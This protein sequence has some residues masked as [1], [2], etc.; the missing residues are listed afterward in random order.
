M[1]REDRDT[2]TRAV[3]TRGWG[4]VT[5]KGRAGRWLDQPI[6]PQTL[7][8]GAPPFLLLRESKGS[9]AKV[10]GPS[11][12]NKWGLLFTWGKPGTPQ[13]SLK[14]KNHRGGWSRGADASPRGIS[15]SIVTPP[16]T[17]SQTQADSP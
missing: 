3:G 6:L 11:R 8:R 9:W 7:G 10:G 14:I 1:L 17:R 16:G 15:P 5:S 13:E 4:S 12:G 2:Q